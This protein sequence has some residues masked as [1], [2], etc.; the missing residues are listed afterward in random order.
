MTTITKPKG[1]LTKAVVMDLVKDAT[2]EQIDRMGDK[3]NA[4]ATMKEAG[5]PCVPGS[6]GLIDSYEHAIV[7]AKEIGYVNADELELLKKFKEN[8]NTWRD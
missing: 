1:N 4:K 5:V 6:D 2:P 7:I 8:Q 3:A